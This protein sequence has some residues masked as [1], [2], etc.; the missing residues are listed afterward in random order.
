MLLGRRSFVLFLQRGT[1]PL[2]R[3]VF[4]CLQQ[5]G[6]V[7]QY[8]KCTFGGSKISFLVHRITPEGIHPSLR[9]YQP[10]VAIFNAKKAQSTAALTFPMPHNPFPLTTDA[11]DVNIC[12]VLEQFVNFSCSIGLL[13]SKTVQGRI[14]LLYL[15]RKLLAVH[16]ALCHSRHFL[17]GIPFVI[18]TDH[19]PLVHTSTRQPDFWSACQCRHLST[20]A[21]YRC[22]LYHALGK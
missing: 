4:D 14:R 16:L 21:E 11:I 15:N 1:P 7:V 22:T 3:I 6:R 5:S 2:P 20:L 18:R 17:E 8:S 12:A 10:E 9:R 13:Q 19:M